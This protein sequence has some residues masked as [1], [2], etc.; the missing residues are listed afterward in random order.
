MNKRA[1]RA[2]E[3]NVSFVQLHGFIGQHSRANFDSRLAKM[4]KAAAGNLWV[5]IFDRR[6]HSFDSSFDQRIGAGRRTAVM[7]VRFTRDISKGVSRAF[8]GLLQCE[9]L[10]MLHLLTIV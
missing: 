3:V 6:G 10:G 9:G 1:A 5:R 4:C 2:H 7:S 8:P